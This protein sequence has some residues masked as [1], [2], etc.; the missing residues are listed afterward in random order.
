MAL[1]HMCIEYGA[2]VAVAHVNYHHRKEADEEENYVV[3][4]CH[5]HGMPVF[6]RNEPFH[7]DRNFEADARAWRYAFFEK[8]V[9]DNQFA[10]VLIAHHMDDLIETYLMQEEKNLEPSYYGLAEDMM[11]HGILVKR[12]LL[13]YT[14]KQL[15]EYCHV[16][17]IRYYTDITNLSDEYTRNR[18]RHETVEK[19]SL[20]E[21]KMILQ[22]IERKNAEKKERICR[23][24]AYVRDG[25]VSLSLY[26]SLCEK[27][28]LAMLRNC[29]EDGA[30]NHRK[31]LSF[32]KQIDAVLMKK[33]DFIIDFGR[34]QIVQKEGFFFLHEAD[35]PYCDIY[36]SKDEIIVGKHGSYFV[37]SGSAGVYAITLHESDFPVRIRNARDGDEIQMR[38]GRKKVS[39]FF[40]DRHIPR[41]ERKVWPVMENRDGNVIFVSGL[42]SDV[43]HYSVNPD[44][45]VLSLFHYTD[46]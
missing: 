2:S 45:N 15:A 16:H 17:G 26:R 7:S 39:R 40:I 28:R 1:L 18:I 43:N 44:L 12:P 4:Y 41:F 37:D 32:L 5:E 33:N 24:S 29:F 23:V 38:F 30:V 3:S 42:G 35:M 36:E 9:K 20:N 27:D 31:S 14:K 6:V 8:T 34:Q 11:Y 19:L 46:E 21:K 10:G 13:G 22:E 25:R